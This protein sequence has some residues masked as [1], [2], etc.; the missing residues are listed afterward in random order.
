MIRYGS[1]K[2]AE[3]DEIAFALTTSS[4]FRMLTLCF[5]KPAA[6]GSNNFYLYVRNNRYRLNVKWDPLM[7]CYNCKL[8]QNNSRAARNWFNAV[9]AQEAVKRC[10]KLFYSYIDSFNECAEMFRA[11][12]PDVLT[13]AGEDGV[14]A[15]FPRALTPAEIELVSAECRFRVDSYIWISPRQVNVYYTPKP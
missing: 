4:R 13:V 1:N 6:N 5:S 10:V 14:E 9:T 15:R 7:H 3:L 11:Y 12:V 8:F 2:Y